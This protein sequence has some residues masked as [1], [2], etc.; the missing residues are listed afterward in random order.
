M[1]RFRS[2]FEYPLFPEKILQ[3]EEKVELPWGKKMFWLSDS[4]GA[5]LKFY[6]HIE[7]QIIN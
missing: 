7:N 3:S 5:S 1:K 6:L 2:D 4:F